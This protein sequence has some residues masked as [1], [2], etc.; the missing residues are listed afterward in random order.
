MYDLIIVP[1]DGSDAAD[2]AVDHA[3][4]QGLAH[5]AELLFLAVV[6]M[7]GGALPEARDDL[8]VEE[9]RAARQEAVESLAA[10][11]EAAGVGATGTVEVGV[12]SRV[13]LESAVERGGDLIVMSTH[14][15]S[16]VGRFLYGS[17]TER[18]IRDGDTPVLAIQ[19]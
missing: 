16:G 15:R 1:T 19:R 9:R 17:V 5:D 10:D 6:E 7:S 18:V 8:A 2:D 14:A 11:A 13:I 4:A 12:P 3:T